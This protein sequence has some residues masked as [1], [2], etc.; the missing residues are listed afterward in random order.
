[1]ALV[2]GEGQRQAVLALEVGV[3][4]RAVGRQADQRRAALGEA[5][6]KPT[7][8]ER[9]GGA[10]GGVVLG[11]EEQDDELAAQILEPNDLA[12]V[13][14]QIEIRRQVAKIQIL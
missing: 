7:E 8:I 12:G 4:L 5:R 3:A 10:A 11:V 1:M 14:R 2:G 6:R 13:R 9:F